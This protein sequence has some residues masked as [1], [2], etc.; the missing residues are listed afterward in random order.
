[1]YAMYLCMLCIYIYI[2]YAKVLLT[3]ESNKRLIDSLETMKQNSEIN[4]DA[5]EQVCKLKLKVNLQQYIHNIHTHT[6]YIHAHT[7]IIYIVHK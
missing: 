1:M 5:A 2:Y 6:Y 3:E 4:N 7:Y